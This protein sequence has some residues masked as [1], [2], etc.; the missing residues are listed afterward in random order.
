MF[1]FNFFKPIKKDKIILS[2]TTYPAR[3]NIVEKTIKSILRQS[4][5]PDEI[6]LWLAPEQFP[7]REAELPKTLL[8]LQKKGLTI[9]W[10]KDIRSYK[11]LIPTLLKYPND[12]IITADD[13]VIYKRDCIKNLYETYIE[14]P[15]CVIA[16]KYAYHFGTENLCPAGYG[17]VL[18][19]P[20]CLY[21]D[22]VNE[23]LFMKLAYDN[24][25]VWFG[26][27]AILAGT[28]VIKCKKASKPRYIKNSQKSRFCLYKKNHNGITG[29]REKVRLVCDYY[30]EQ[31]KKMNI[32]I[33]CEN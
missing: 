11:K 5:K 24:D 32:K 6:I 17:G 22:I 28:K 20:N 33:L 25:D 18:Y 31:L 10:Y 21:K 12:I 27:M 15:N 13:D 8:N 29:T 4:L 19:P 7:K 16:H 1:L 30:S 2:L 9:C 23:N 26:M 3:I 14:N